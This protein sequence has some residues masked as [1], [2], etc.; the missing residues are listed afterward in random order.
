M[1]REKDL[2]DCLANWQLLADEE[3]TRHWLPGDHASVREA[4]YGLPILRQE[5]APLER[6]P[7]KNDRGRSGREIDVGDSEKIDIGISE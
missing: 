5:N 6:C 1:D 7:F 3:D 2:I 4:G